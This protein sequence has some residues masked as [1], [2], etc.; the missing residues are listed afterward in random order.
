MVF[1]PR[2]GAWR[3][4]TTGHRKT[5]THKQ[6]SP[7]L[8]LFTLPRL[9]ICQYLSTCEL[10]QA[11]MEVQAVLLVGLLLPLACEHSFHA[12]VVQ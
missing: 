5:Q 3:H 7:Y 8:A 6:G 9:F 2:L 11:V 10:V 12:G 1:S 4:G